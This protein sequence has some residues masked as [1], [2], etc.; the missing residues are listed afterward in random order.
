MAVD[1]PEFSHYLKVGFSR[2]M[3]ELSF[4]A[5][6][7]FNFEPAR[8]IMMPHHKLEMWPGFD[9]RLIMKDSGTFLNIEPAY[10]VV[11]NETALVVMRRILELSD[12]RGLEF[13]SEV[14][15]EFKNAVVV[16]SYNNKSYPITSVAFDITPKS[17]FL[18]G[19]NKM[20][21]EEYYLEKYDIKIEDL[22]QHLLLSVDKRS[23]QEIY[24]VPE[25]CRMTG[26]SNDL[27]DDFRAMREIKALTHSD[28]PAKARECVKLFDSIEQN[29][30]CRELMKEMGVEFAR[31]PVKLRGYKLDAGKMIMGIS[32]LTNK[33]IEHD[34]ESCGRDL[35][36]MVQC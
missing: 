21:F 2:M 26:I 19:G 32:E 8:N 11:R 23:G 27:M 10:K 16:T 35:D 1:S 20:S 5:I 24:L 14:A 34:I 7:R 15:K 9:F 4:E 18:Y 31:E 3:K 13:H 12:A 17:T 25:L 28:A 36:K 30:V 29:E 22:N 6:G 33:R